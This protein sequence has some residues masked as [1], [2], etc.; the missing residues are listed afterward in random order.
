MLLARMLLL[1]TALI[2]GSTFVA[3]KICLGYISPIELMAF[4]FAIG[5]PV[6]FVLM[7]INRSGL[8]FGTHKGRLLAASLV[9]AAHFFIQITGIKYTTATNTGWIIALSPL[10]VAALSAIFLREKITGKI[11]IG[12]AVATVGILLLISKGHLGEFSWLSSYGDWLVLASA[13]T[14]AIYTVMTRDISRDLN[15]LA[16]TFF[17]LIPSAVISMLSVV[18][19]SDWHRFANIPP[20]A[21]ISILFLGILGTALGHWF[22]Q[23]GVAR[24]GASRAG[25][26]LYLEPVATT[27]IALPYLREPLGIFTIVGGL[28][29]LLGV[30]ISQYE[31][32]G[33]KAK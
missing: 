25:I 3:T 28:A 29:V 23:L 21:I 9:I 11:L 17:L 33:S 10:V 15:P 6:L 19:F 18:L 12:I 16:V 22:W 14:W 1:I 32:N 31:R 8:K 24:I 2:W 13:H 7:L 5:L 27:A 20:E 30:W 26:F 4:R